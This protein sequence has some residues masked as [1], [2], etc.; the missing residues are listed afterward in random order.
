MTCPLLAEEGHEFFSFPRFNEPV[1]EVGIHLRVRSV[2]TLPHGDRHTRHI[3]HRLR[4]A[5]TAPRLTRINASLVRMF[6]VKQSM[7]RGALPHRGTHCART[8][9]SFDQK[10][11]VSPNDAFLSLV[12]STVHILA[13]SFTCIRCARRTHRSM[14][15]KV[16]HQTHTTN[17]HLHRPSLNFGKMCIIVTSY[18]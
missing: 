1:L 8:L 14:F 16:R 15:D 7:T 3:P 5:A 12:G 9:R 10:P 13:H 2:A 18:F 17:A 6:H 11:Y 4:D